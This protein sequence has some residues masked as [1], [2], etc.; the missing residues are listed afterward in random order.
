MQTDFYY[1]RGQAD[2]FSPEANEDFRCYVRNPAT[3]HAMCEDY[4][5]GAT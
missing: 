3:I 2:F 1:E 4:R 5:A